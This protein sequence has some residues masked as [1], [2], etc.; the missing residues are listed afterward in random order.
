MADTNVVPQASAR[1]FPSTGRAVRSAIAD[2]L[3]RWTLPIILIGILLWMPT[4]PQLVRVLHIQAYETDLQERAGR[5]V[6]RSHVR[7]YELAGLAISLWSHELAT[8]AEPAGSTVP[9]W[10]RALSQSGLLDMYPTFDSAAKSCASATDLLADLEGQ[11]IVHQ[12]IARVWA[13]SDSADTARL[14]FL[15]LM[16]VASSRECAV[17]S[18][19]RW[20]EPKL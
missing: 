3:R 20:P 1:S 19:A 15:N 5:L 13:S 2:L 8:W 12:E 17:E 18:R 7:L 11:R 4:P 10:R 9:T 14:G 16:L 6:Q